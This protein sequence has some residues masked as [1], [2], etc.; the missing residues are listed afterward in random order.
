MV[1]RFQSTSKLKPQFE[2]VLGVT[3]EFKFNQNLTRICT[4]RYQ[5][6]W[7]FPWKNWKNSY[8]LVSCGTNSSGEISPDHSGFRIPL[9]FFLSLFAPVRFFF[10]YTFTHKLCQQRF[11]FFWWSAIFFNTIFDRSRA[12]NLTSPLSASSRWQS[13]RTC[14]QWGS[15]IPRS[16]AV[17]NGIWMLFNIYL[18]LIGL[19]SQNV[20]KEN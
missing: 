8:S 2:F 17:E 19:F 16:R 15:E 20:A 12:G 6:I 14:W 7:V 4:A 10:G 18:N 13:S 11:G 1:G 3:E 5:W 9:S